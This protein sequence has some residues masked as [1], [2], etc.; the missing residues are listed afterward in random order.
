MASNQLTSARLTSLQYELAMLVGQELQLVP[1]LRRFFPPALK[2]LRCRAAHVWL[3]S[4]PDQAPAHCFSYPARD[5]A[6]WHENQRFMNAARE[7][8]KAATQ[9]RGMALDERTWLQ[10]IPLEEAGFCVL[11]RDDE[12]IDPMTI[13]AIKPIF[14]RLANAC[15]ASLR[16]QQVE[17]LQALAADRELRLRSVLETIGE[18][19]FQTDSTGRLTFLTPAWEAISGT[20]INQALGQPLVDFL[21]AVDRP[22]LQRQ[23][24]GKLDEP[25]GERMELRL[26]TAGGELRDVVIR[27]RR[28]GGA[29]HFMP[30]Q[31]HPRQ[32]WYDRAADD[33]QQLTGTIIDVTELRRAERLKRE[34]TATVSHE[35]RTPLSAIVGAIGLLEG[36]AGGELPTRARELIAIAEKNS[37]RLRHLIDDLLDMEK[38]LAGKMRF[39]MTTLDISKL[40]ATAMSEHAPLAARHQVTLSCQPG[41]TDLEAQAD[42]HRFTQVL[43]NLLSNAIKFSPSGAD[44]AVASRRQGAGIR[45]EVTDRGPGIDPAIASGLFEPFTQ[46]DASDSRHK[47]GTGLGLAISRALVEQMNGRIGVESEPGHG[48]TFW[49]ELPAAEAEEPA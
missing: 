3:R 15:R 10:L 40:I 42:P 34:F 44:V 17:Q 43:S 22:L 41:G 47:G 16:H 5:S 32:R 27:L 35:L 25:T 23:L 18:V 9:P 45:V 48:A 46:A 36:G 28:T 4:E 37:L 39:T 12:P 30:T 11:I 8:A 33:Q 21:A 14:T 20:A 1:M 38:L 29:Q 24:Q 31:A 19:I 26:Q 2:A 49:F 13:A 6:V 7:F